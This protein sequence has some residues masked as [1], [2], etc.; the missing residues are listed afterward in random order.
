MLKDQIHRTGRHFPGA[1]YRSFVDDR[2]RGLG[3]RVGGPVPQGRVGQSTPRATHLIKV[4]C[5]AALGQRPYLEVF[6]TDFPTPEPAKS[7]T[8][9]PTPISR[10][11]GR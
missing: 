9:W 6:G 7:P 3:A 5:Q 10:Y 1:G 11:C 8:R 2:V 4:A